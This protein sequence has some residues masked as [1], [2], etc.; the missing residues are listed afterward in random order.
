[1][2]FY[3]IARNYVNY[4]EINY[5]N[6]FKYTWWHKYPIYFLLLLT[7]LLWL[8]GGWI[9]IVFFIVGLIIIQASQKCKSVQDPRK[10]KK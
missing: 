1:M 2:D 10:L 7:F 5:N 8:I 3:S 4:E 9:W 6:V